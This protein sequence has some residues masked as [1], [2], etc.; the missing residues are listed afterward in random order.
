MPLTYTILMYVDCTSYN[1]RI[2]ETVG[3]YRGVGL[4]RFHSMLVQQ[5]LDN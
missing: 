5:L 1:G 2:R 3:L 4:A